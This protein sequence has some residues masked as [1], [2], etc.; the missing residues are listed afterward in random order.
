MEGHVDAGHEHEGVLAAARLGFGARVGGQGLQAL[1]GARHGVLHAGQV[2]VDDLEE[3]AGPLGDP[4]DVVLDV[5]RLDAGLVGTEG[6]HA[7]VRGAVLVALDQGVHGGA[8]LED[9]G[10]GR[11]HGHDAPVGA[12]GGVL[13]QGVPGEGRALDQG[14]GLGQARRGG[15]GDRGQGDLGELGEVE[16]S[17]GM[18]IGHSASGHLG[19]VVAH[20]GDDGEAELGAGV[21]VGA[22]PDL[23]GGL[24]D[25][26]LVQAHATG[27]NSLARVDVGG[28]LGLGHG[29][30]AGDDLV[31]DTA[32]DLQHEAAAADEPGA[33]DADLDAIRELDGA[34]HDVGPARQHVAGAIGCGGGRNLL[35]GGR[36]PHAVDQRRLHAGDL[37]RVVAGVD[38]VEVAGDAC[39]GGHVRRRRHSDAAQQAAGGG[40]GGASRAS[41]RLGGRGHGGARGAPPDGEA[42]AH[43]C[44]QSALRSLGGVGQ[45]QAHVDDPAGAGLL[46]GGHPAIDLDDGPGARLGVQLGQ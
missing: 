4:G 10:D 41:R 24:G 32:G 16:Q 14:A 5:G 8:A 11:L 1:D 12:Q 25:A 39:E 46:Q 2:V 18:T 37:G 40:G 31:A 23:T 17:L 27:L 43:E 29:G 30:A 3:L 20:Q 13:P 33:L 35:G 44:D 21:G 38:G 19:R 9:D 6:P 45:L 34:Q 42:L 26:H 28:R 36:Q 15:H 22:L 7:V